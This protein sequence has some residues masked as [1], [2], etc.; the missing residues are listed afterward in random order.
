MAVVI[1]GKELA[2][3]IRADLKK[4]VDILKRDGIFPKLA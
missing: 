4:E 1:N 3:K 2:Q